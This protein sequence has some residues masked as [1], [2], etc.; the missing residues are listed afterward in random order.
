MKITVTEKIFRDAFIRPTKF[1]YDG[2][3]KLFNYYDQ[4]DYESEVE[5]DVIAICR[6]WQELTLEEM[7]DQFDMTLEEFKEKT[8]IIETNDD[9]D[10]EDPTYLIR[11][12]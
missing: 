9:I 8:E 7:K 10:N 4:F 6:E 11:K 5:L 3:T 2:L 12:F 1:S